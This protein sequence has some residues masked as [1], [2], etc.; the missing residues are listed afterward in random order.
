[1]VCAKHKDVPKAKIKKF[2]EARKAKAGTAPAAK[3]APARRKAPKASPK[4][5]RARKLQGQYLGALKS[6][7]EADK[8]KVKAVAKDKGVADALKL[9]KSLK[10]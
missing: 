9:A 2:R 6:L 8:A 5:A 4:L 7:T 10:K 3:A 1:M